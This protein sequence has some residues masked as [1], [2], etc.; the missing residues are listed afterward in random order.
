MDVEVLVVEDCPHGALASTLVAQTLLDIGLTDVTV[1]TTVIRT[2]REA[3]LRHFCGSPTVLIN[4]RD[5]FA[6]PGAAPAL[7]CRVY[8]TTEG[9][10]GVPDARTL[11]RAFEDAAATDAT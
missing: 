2:E 5:P 6:H 11:R 10:S 3:R 4:G 1:V 8:L 9:S 7:A